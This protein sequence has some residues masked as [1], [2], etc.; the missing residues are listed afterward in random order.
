[1]QIDRYVGT[2]QLNRRRIVHF[3]TSV[4]RREEVSKYTFH[5]RERERERHCI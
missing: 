1:M 5:E 4:E 2:E 3:N